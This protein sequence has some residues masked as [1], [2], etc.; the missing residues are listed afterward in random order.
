MKV[1]FTGTQFG[2]SPWQSYLVSKWLEEHGHQ[3][4]LFAHGCCCGADIE[5]HRMVRRMV[6]KGA[7]IAVYPSTAKTRAPIPPDA[8]FVADPKPPLERDRDIV[9]AGNN[10]LLA[11]PKQQ[12]EVLRSGTWTTIR[13]AWRKRIKVEIYYPDPLTKEEFNKR[14][15]HK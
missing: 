10:L 9:N 7:Y 3:A 2:M 5:F 8:N 6:G 14:F 12:H 13:Y 15:A 4:S 1:S 11:T